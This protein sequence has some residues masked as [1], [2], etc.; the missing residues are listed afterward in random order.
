MFK[1]FKKFPRQKGIVIC[2]EPCDK[3]HLYSTINLE[4]MKN[5]S[6]ILRT[7]KN[8]EAFRLWTYL[9]SNQHGYQFGLSGQVLTDEW[10]MSKEV[11]QEAVNILIKEG[12]L[13][14]IEGTTDYYYFKEK[15]QKRNIS[16]F[17]EGENQ[18]RDISFFK[19]CTYPLLE[20]EEIQKR[21]CA[22][23]EKRDISSF[24]SCTY[25]LLKE[26]PYHQEILYNNINSTIDT[27]F[28]EELSYSDILAMF[29]EDS[30]EIREGYCYRNDGKVYKVSYDF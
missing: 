10:G 29:P 7:K 11:Y 25:P 16:S 23:F 18:K 26:D 30:Y 15:P 24:K 20:N 14:L 1:K 4:A 27:T 21:E 5:A 17:N 2:K 6:K 12:F 13:E 8:A 28:S 3:E 9:A 19:N 22:S